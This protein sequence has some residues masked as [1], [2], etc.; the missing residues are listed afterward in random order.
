MIDVFGVLRPVILQLAIVGGLLGGCASVN[1]G[2]NATLQE[3]IAAA[4]TDL[5]TASLFITV[6]AGLPPCAKNG[7][8][9][10]SSPALVALLDK[11]RIA[12][13]AALDAV[14]ALIAAGSP[15]EKIL[16]ALQEAERAVVVLRNLRS[17]TGAENV[18]PPPAVGVAP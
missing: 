17:D 1:V 8:R 7:P 14:D 15:E 16:V 12:A 11:A 13:M 5:A 4:R 18:L 9:P 10:C 3:R 6:Y 2:P